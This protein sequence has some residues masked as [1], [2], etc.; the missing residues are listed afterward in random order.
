[1]CRVVLG[2]RKWGGNCVES[3]CRGW[4]PSPKG[5]GRQCRLAGGGNS[6]ET[7]GKVVAWS[8]WNCGQSLPQAGRG[9]LIHVHFGPDSGVR[10]LRHGSRPAQAGTQL[11]A[12]LPLWSGRSWGQS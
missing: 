11:Q 4:G 10:K 8:R 1:M 12:E 9:Q 3:G 6:Q 5:R 7:P 2:C